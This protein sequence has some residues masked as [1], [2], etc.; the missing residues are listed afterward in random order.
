MK[1]DSI[2]SMLMREL[3]NYSFSWQSLA[4]VTCDHHNASGCFHVIQV[5]DVRA[6]TRMI[7]VG[8]CITTLLSS[9]R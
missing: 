4:I 9:T 2:Y 7:G 5:S 1:P 6:M 8:Y 3:I